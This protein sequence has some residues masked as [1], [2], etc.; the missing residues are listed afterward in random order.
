M[1][2]LHDLV[3]RAPGMSVID[4]GMNRGLNA[5]EMMDAGARL[6]HGCDLAPDCVTFA[7]EM[8]ADLDPFTCQSQFEVVDLTKG[9]TAFAPFGDAGWDIVLFIGVYHKLKRAPSKPYL[10]LGATPMSAEELSQLMTDLGRRTNRYLGFRGDLHD[11]PQID[12]D[13]HKAGLRRVA[14]SEISALGPTA[15]YRREH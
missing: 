2:G 7:R 6:V 8:F 3:V 5:Y 4:I 13:L 11:I 1:D 10:D 15:I 14:L 12:D 9:I